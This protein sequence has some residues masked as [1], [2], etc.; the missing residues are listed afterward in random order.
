MAIDFVSAM[1]AGSGINTTEV[2]DA[3]V[4]AQRAPLQQSIDRLKTKADVQISAYGYVKS[5]LTTLQA[6]F[7]ALNDVSEVKNFSVS[8]TDATVLSG[9]G[10]TSAIAGDYDVV[11]SALANKTVWNSN[12]INVDASTDTINSGASFDITLTVGGSA[13]T[14][15]VS[16][17]TPDGIV[18]AINDADLG[19]T[20]AL[21]DTGDGFVVT[22]AG[23]YGSDNAFTVDSSTIDSSGNA[24]LVDA[25]GT[26]V[27]DLFL[28]AAVSSATDASL[29]VNGVA[30]TRTTNT[31]SDAIP[32][33]TLTLSDT[34]SETISV[35]QDS[36]TL[37]TALRNLVD[38]YNEV[39]TI[40]DQL[41]TGADDD[42]AAVGSLATDSTFR[43]L[44]NSIRSILTT[45]S[46]TAS[47]NINY[48]S[49][50][51]IQFQRDGSLEIDEDRF[52]TALSDE[53]DDVVQA[54]TAGTDDQSIYGTASRGIAGDV[55][56]LIYDMTKTTG[57]ITSV[58]TDAA[59][60]LTDYEDK[61]ADLDA[62]MEKVRERYIA[63]F[64]AMQT[65]VDQMN[66]TR[67][68]LEQQLANLPFTAKD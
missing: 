9:A 66:S 21:I 65:I 53:F 61:L 17:D 14:V 41:T 42:D 64:S 34:G 33:V 39:D 35:T 20:A 5:A 24:L 19:V 40:F 12:V 59:D 27:N 8:S 57:T 25:N 2:V 7:D 4:E 29:T 54:L 38:I 16:T 31:V 28:G 67:D 63:Q 56:V 68:Y 45:P 58:L 55:S 36:A 62:R 3:L 44:R 48:L 1:G 51:G 11:I 43:S 32:G 47:G 6:A 13:Q 23:E 30:V 18:D 50:I 15:T 46:S 22:I 26:A 49:D 37:E 60:D 10:T 52:T